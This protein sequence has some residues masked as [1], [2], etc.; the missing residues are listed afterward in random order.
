MIHQLIRSHVVLQ[1]T[2]FYFPS[3]LSI[4]ISEW[5]ILFLAKIFEIISA[6]LLGR[7]WHWP[8]IQSTSTI[9]MKFEA[10]K[11]SSVSNDFFGQCNHSEYET[12]L[13][14]KWKVVY[15]SII[16]KKKKKTAEVIKIEKKKKTKKNN[17]I[18]W[19]LITSIYVLQVCKK[20][21]RN[22]HKNSWNFFFTSQTFLTR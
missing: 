17:V 15:K 19:S 14:K 1:Q 18:L 21:L 5:K 9:S 6:W 12:I 4:L 7:D 8:L 22:S 16:Y 13:K 10:K 3:N 20:I 2:A 11:Y